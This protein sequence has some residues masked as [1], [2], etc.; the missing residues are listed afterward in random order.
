MKKFLFLFFVVLV[1]FVFGC[2]TVEEEGGSGK[3]ASSTASGTLVLWNFE[4]NS[5]D[6]W[7]GKGKWANACTVNSDSKFVKEGKYSLKI[8]A[9]GS[10]GWNQDIALN[11]GPFSGDF[12][13][14]KS[15]T[16]DVYV[17]ETSMKGLEYGQIFLVISGSANSWYQIPQGLKPGWNKLVYK[18]ESD[19]IAGDIWHI[20]FVFNSGGDFK[21][22]VYIDNVVGNF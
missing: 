3:V 13:N 20:Y 19:N 10:K 11:D 4:S 15:I 2:A 21:G 7:Y 8:D 18:L 6:G 14:L 12:G 1:V 22:P 16:M 9:K 5:T 17:P